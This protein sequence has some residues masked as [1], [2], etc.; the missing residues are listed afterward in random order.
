MCQERN[1]TNLKYSSIKVD[2][3]MKYLIEALQDLNVVGC[4]CGHGKY[5]TTIVVIDKKRNNEAYDL[6][7][8]KTLWC[9]NKYEY[10]KTRF[11]LKDKEGYYYIPETLE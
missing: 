3:C 4:C 1:T 5:P 2:R 10:R 8:N 6:I 7:S 11:Y 9:K